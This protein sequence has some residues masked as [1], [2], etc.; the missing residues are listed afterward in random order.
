MWSLILI[1]LKTKH[2]FA[3]Q[4][5]KSKLLRCSVPNHFKTHMNQ[6][7]SPWT[8]RQYIPLK[9]KKNLIYYTVQKP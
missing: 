3:G 6:N 2:S 1:G 8:W 7:M 4:Q 9:H 5:S